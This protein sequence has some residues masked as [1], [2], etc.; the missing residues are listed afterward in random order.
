MPA[1]CLLGMSRGGRDL[2][3]CGESPCAEDLMP[4]LQAGAHPHP[5]HTLPEVPPAG[6]HAR[7]V[8]EL[9]AQR[10]LGDGDDR[11]PVRMD[12]ALVTAPAPV[13]PQSV[14]RRA[15]GV[16]LRHRAATEAARLGKC[17][18]VVGESAEQPQKH[19]A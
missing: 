10:I 17:S 11:S 19:R 4:Q 18:L 6:E 1:C 13:V 12:Q 8:L 9:G 15:V 2:R 7:G 3:R 14:E 16:Q 5:W